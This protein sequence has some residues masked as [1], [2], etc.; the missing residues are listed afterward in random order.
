MVPD[1]TIT[2]AEE[3]GMLNTEI[4]KELRRVSRDETALNT[5]YRDSSQEPFRISPSQAKQIIKFE[6]LK[7]VINSTYSNQVSQVKRRYD[8]RTVSDKVLSQAM[9]K[10]NGLVEAAS[11]VNESFGNGSSKKTFERRLQMKKESFDSTIRPQK[12]H[13][14]IRDEVEKIK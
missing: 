1:I 12:S 6:K 7:Q 13:E 4:L 10:N 14:I 11:E 9:S 3:G 2:P 5:S 8:I